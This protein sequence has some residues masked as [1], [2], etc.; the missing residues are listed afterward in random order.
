[1]QCRYATEEEVIEAMT[2]EGLYV[3]LPITNT[4]DLTEAFNRILDH[5]QGEQDS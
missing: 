1:M 5:L 3:S 4:A 2:Q